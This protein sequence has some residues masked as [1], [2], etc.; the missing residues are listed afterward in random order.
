MVK[1][2]PRST[3]LPRS[4]TLEELSFL[5]FWPWTVLYSCQWYEKWLE[6]KK[7]NWWKFC[8]YDQS[9]QLLR[10]FAMN[11]ISTEFLKGD[12]LDLRWQQGIDPYGTQ[13]RTGGQWNMKMKKIM[14]I[15]SPQPLLAQRLIKSTVRTVFSC[16]ITL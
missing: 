4:R 6:L 15:Y 13:K 10:K 11:N 14:A 12:H 3:Q 1:E 9:D 5:K 8:S 16:M 2:V 7:Y